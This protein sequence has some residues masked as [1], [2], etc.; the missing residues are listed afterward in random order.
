MAAGSWLYLT[1]PPLPHLKSGKESAPH[2]RT[3]EGIHE[4]TKHE[5]PNMGP[6]TQLAFKK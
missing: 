4:I 2:L 1:E 5:N 3:V 6:D